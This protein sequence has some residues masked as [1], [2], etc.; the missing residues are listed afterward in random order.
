LKVI[1]RNNFGISFM[2]RILAITARHCS[3]LLCLNAIL[4]ATAYY[5]Y[6][7]TAKVW[8][9]NTQMILPAQT[10]NLDASLGTLGSLRNSNPSFSDQVNPLKVQA[11]ILTSDVLMEKVLASDPEKEK[12]NRLSSYK[13]LFKVAPQEQ[14]TII[15]LAVNGSSPEIARQRSLILIQAYE[16]RLNELRQTNS[17]ARQKFSQ[18]E[19]DKAKQAL[20]QA[21]LRL[22]RFKQSS[23]Q[24]NTEEQ[25]KGIVTTMNALISARAQALAQSQASVNRAKALST[26]LSLAPKEAINSLG[27]GEN[28]NFQFIRTKLSEIDASLVQKRANFTD[29]HPQVRSLLTQREQSQRQLQQYVVQATQGAGKV[30]TGVSGQ[31]QGRALLI[32]QMILAESD[33][34][35]QQQQAQLLDKQIASLNANLQSLPGSQAQIQELQRQV[36]VTEGVYKGLVAQVQQYN[37]NAFDAYPN[38]QLLDGP[39]VDSKPVSPK[40]SFMVINALMASVIGSIALILLLESRNPLLSPKDLQAF[41]FPIVVGIPKLKPWKTKLDWGNETEVEFQRLASAVSLQPLENRRLLVTSAAASEGKTTVSIGLACALVD[42]GFRVL[43]VDGDFRQAE[44]SR[45]LGY[46]KQSNVNNLQVIHPNLDLLPATPNQ[47]KI[48]EWVRG[49][50]F[51]KTLADI[52]LAGNYDYVIIDSAPVGLT[53]ETALMATIISNVLFVIRPNTSYKNSVNDSLAQLSQHN[54]HVLGLVVNS[55]ES[56]AKSYPYRFSAPLVKI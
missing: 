25:T 27:L 12:F 26:R 28:Q 37:I 21:Q 42:L 8:T 7:S 6:A 23:G 51:E 20:S 3:W 31:A 19:L 10:T 34:I 48:V 45:S 38:V 18:Q 52:E 50:R 44:L 35:A 4:L 40:L 53:S 41:K 30:D 14:S 39:Q 1:F 43:V 16:N 49:G 22:T 2:N 5:S 24:V 46:T 15:S 32:Q 47:G 36:E 56:G 9:A 17:Q 55:L 33:G 13:G 54:A 29:E 11:S